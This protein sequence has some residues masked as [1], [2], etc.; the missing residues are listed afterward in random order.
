MPFSDEEITVRIR[1]KESRKFIADSRKVAA[2]V[3]NIRRSARRADGDLSI[4]NARLSF[5]GAIVRIIRPVFLATAIGFLA[6]AASAGAGGVVALTSA[7]TPLPG[8]LT[9]GSAAAGVFAQTI[10]VFAFA[11]SGIKT[12]LGGK[13]LLGEEL[14]PEKL[15]ML[16]PAAREFAGVIHDEL[17]PGIVTLQSEIQKGLFPGLT[18]AIRI[19]VPALQPLIPIFVETGRVIGS[20]A[21]QAARIVTGPFGTDLKNILIQNNKWLQQ[22]APAAFF[23]A[24]AFLNLTIAAQP[25]VT[26]IIKVVVG[27]SRALSMFTDSARESGKLAGFFRLT[28]VVATSLG[29]TLRDLGATLYN[30]LVAAFPLGMSI[31]DVFQRGAFWLRQWSSSLKGRA[32]LAVYFAQ[33]K[34]PLWEAGRLIRDVFY[35]FLKL[36]T[37]PGLTALI[38]MLRTDLL[39][40][41]YE[42]FSTTSTELGPSFISLFTSLVKLLNEFTGVWVITVK[43]LATV[44]NLTSAI[45]GANPALRAFATGFVAVAASIKLLKVL[46]LVSGLQKLVTWIKVTRAAYIAQKSA[47]LGAIAVHTIHDAALKAQT[48][49]QVE[50]EVATNASTLAA[51]RW[52]IVT[53]LQATQA[54]IMAGASKVQAGA[55]WLL[56]AAQRAYIVITDIATYTTLRLR[57]ATILTAAA[58]KVMA[59]ATKALEGAVWLLNAALLANPIGLIILALVALAAAVV[60]LYFK[61]AWFRHAIQ[62]VWNWMKTAATDT[63]H[64]IVGAFNAIISK[65]KEAISW[66]KQAINWASRASKNTADFLGFSKV[67]GA[68]HLDGKKGK[69]KQHLPFPHRATGG[70]IPGGSGGFAVVGEQGPELARFPIGTHITPNRKTT[71]AQYPTHVPGAGAAGETIVHAHLHVDGKEMAR[72]V[73]RAGQDAQARR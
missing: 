32:T 2:E 4:L 21:A 58:Q 56:Y 43:L 47:E 10:G 40:V 48:L 17:F 68:L 37:A 50:Q 45:F 7:L 34:A 16:N 55:M 49:A 35:Y 52:R 53:A 36:G 8:L 25:L 66:F 33:I 22:I 65:L 72:T 46:A 29:N 28:R 14:D 13:G 6:Q 41:L 73:V 3:D 54:K 64:W 67:R 30:V 24:N 69:D 70:M 27:L 39:P 62:D 60:V 57:A 20:L 23:L 9:A 12:A 11:L 18:E 59:V 15:A 44:L 42:L 71:S 1:L 38:E 26:W 5:L 31:L 63:A 19:L 51:I 61:W